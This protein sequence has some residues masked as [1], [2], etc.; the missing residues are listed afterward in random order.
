VAERHICRV[1][2]KHLIT[3]YLPGQVTYNLG[4]YPCVKP[5][6]VDE[7]SG[8]DER[9]LDEYRTAGIELVQIHEEWNDA[10][11]LFGADKL[12]PLNRGG[13]E[14][15]MRLAHDRGFKVLLYASTGFFEERDPDF[16]RDW[17]RQ[18]NA[19]VELWYRYA[20]CSPS[21]PSWRAYLLP[22]LFRLMD[23][24]GAD[25]IYDDCGYSPAACRLPATPDEVLAFPEAPGN[26]DALADLLA[27]VCAEVKRRNGIFKVHVSGTS[28]PKTDLQVYDYLWVGEGVR[29]LDAQRQIVKHNRPYVTPCFDLSRARPANEDE[30]YLHTIPYLQFPLLIGGRPVTGERALVPGLKYLDETKDFWTGHMRAIHRH[31]KA[32]PQGPHSYG[33][34]DAT[35]GRPDAKARYFHWLSLYRPMVSPGTWAYIEIGASD[36]FRARLPADVVASVYVNQEF[37]LVLANYGHTRCTIPTREA[38]VPVTRSAAAACQPA[39]EFRL[40]ARSLLILRRQSR[41]PQW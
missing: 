31:W 11:R 29:D 36:L 32:H 27:L 13:L 38:F 17:A 2:R 16:R 25:G 28:S 1:L 30:L 23:E 9:L 40:P 37:W 22:R 15:F 10:E 7:H 14:R 41:E 26:D 34:W 21:S 12:T 18:G 39:T 4:E 35:P 8:Q 3:D 6:E 5:W 20:R 33:W 19:L 24:F